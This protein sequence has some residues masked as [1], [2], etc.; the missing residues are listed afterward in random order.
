MDDELIDSAS[1]S[2]P[3]VNLFLPIQQH[4][5]RFF[6]TGRVG[7]EGEKAGIL[8]E[9]FCVL[10]LPS[11]ARECYQFFVLILNIAASVLFCLLHFHGYQV[12]TVPRW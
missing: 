9:G 5:P 4:L 7:W 2:P 10:L 1:W 12:L 8:G 6:E 3:L 11:S